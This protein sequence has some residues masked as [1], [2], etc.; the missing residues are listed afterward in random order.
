M[1]RKET[2]FSHFVSWIAASVIALIVFVFSAGYF[3]LSYQHVSGSLE[4]VVELNANTVSR[5]ISVNPGYWQFEHVRL[6]ELLSRRSLAGHPEIRRLTDTEGTLI[7]ESLDDVPLPRITRSHVI[8][9][10]GVAAGTIEISRSLR[11][12]LMQTV[13]MT[14]IAAAFGCGVFLLL[15]RLPIRTIRAAERALR[16]SHQDLERRVAERTHEL[17]TANEALQREISEHLRTENA[18]RL[19]EGKFSKAFQASPL[20]IVISTL[21]EDVLLEVNDTFL[22]QTEYDRDEVI[23][24]TSG[25]LRLWEDDAKRAEIASEVRRQGS[26]VNVEVGKR[27]KSG[28]IV[29]MLF[30]GQMLVIEGKPCLFS[31]AFDITDQNKLE[32]QLRQAQKME[33]I[34]LLAGGIAHDFN[35]YLTALLGYASLLSARVQGSEK[36]EHYVTQIR[37]SAEKSVDLVKQLL[38]FSRKQKIQPIL[39]NLNDRIRKMEQL[40]ARLIGEDI[41]I[42]TNLAELEL[43]IRVDPGQLDQVLL[44]LAANARDAMPGGG[45]LSISS[46]MVLLSEEDVRLLTIDNPGRYVV[47]SVSD[48]GAGFDK[49]T[50]DRIFEPFFTT[51]E[52]GKGTGLGLSTVYGIVTQHGGGITVQS[53][54]GEGS[55]FRIFMPLSGSFPETGARVEEAALPGGSETILLCEDSEE[56]RHL[57]QA[58]LEDLGYTVIMTEDGEQSVSLFQALNDRIDLVILD[59]ILPKKNG[60]EVSGVMISIKPDIPILFMS[61]YSAD[62]INRK[63]FLREDMDFLAKPA[64][65]HVLASKVREMLDG[66]RKK[67]LSA[68]R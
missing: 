10:A 13:L 44:N 22:R 35:N 50:A 46:D 67:E 30:S 42:E 38:A 47:F 40:L 39:V 20:W 18:L 48:T 17:S 59:I 9:D 54:P 33:A 66:N 8:M 31:I 65:P 7:A 62:I 58:I 49:A 24:K 36:L 12:I 2:S 25:E 60:R 45:T 5:I 6:G 55:I 34:G 16:D 14:L 29:R 32:E 61:G 23:G 3:L 21:D 57:M 11:P 53:V 51:K 15:Y 19:S 1:S 63:G 68:L 56:V 37:S 41:A 28:K 64:L 4:T 26:L 27:T 52:M 43:L